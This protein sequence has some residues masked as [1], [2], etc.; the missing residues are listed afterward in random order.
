MKK[1]NLTI[2]DLAIMVK[3]GFDEIHVDFHEEIGE[4]KNEIKEIKTE[5]KVINKRLDKLETLP[6]NHER[7]ISAVETDVKELK[8]T[9]AM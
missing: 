2:D 6:A 7:R 4:V 1:K 9:F 3:K 8:E 5:I